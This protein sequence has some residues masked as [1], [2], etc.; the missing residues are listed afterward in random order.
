MTVQELIDIL[1]DCPRERVVILQ[2]ENFGFDDIKVLVQ[3]KVEECKL[4]IN[5]GTYAEVED[6]TPPGSIVEAI[7]ICND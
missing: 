3:K 1:S 4:S 7:L 6:D 2:N 5:C